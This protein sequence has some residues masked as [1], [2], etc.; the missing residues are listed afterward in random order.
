MEN[1]RIVCDRDP[2]QESST[3]LLLKIDDF[4]ICYIL[5]IVSLPHFFLILHTSP[6]ILTHSFSESHQKDRMLRDNIKT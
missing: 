4:L 1:M 6:P 5:V 2:Y 3:G